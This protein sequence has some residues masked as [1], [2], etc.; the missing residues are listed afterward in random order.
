MPNEFF[1]QNPA[2]ILRLA[3]AAQDVKHDGCDRHL[4]AFA[5]HPT[6]KGDIQ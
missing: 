3:G 5:T 2:F 4:F 1:D 6:L